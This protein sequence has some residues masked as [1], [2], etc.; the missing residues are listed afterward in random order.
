M[1]ALLA[2]FTKVPGDLPRL[3]DEMLEDPRCHLVLLGGDEQGAVLL[4][5]WDEETVEEVAH[6]LAALTERVRRL[7]LVGGSLA[8]L[9]PATT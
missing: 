3:A 1:V 6:S 4:T 2:E 8:T 7:S 9:G 5:V